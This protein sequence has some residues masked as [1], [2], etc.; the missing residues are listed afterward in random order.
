MPL[1]LLTA[2]LSLLPQAPGAQAATPDD[3]T[4]WLGTAYRTSAA[5]GDV[6]GDGLADLVIGRNGPLSL[7]LGLP[8]GGLERFGPERAVGREVGVSCEQAG[9]PHLVD[10]D[11]DGDLDLVALH[12][13][14]GS[15]GH[16]AWFANDGKGKFAPPLR[17]QGVGGGELPI[18]GQASAIALADWDRD[19]QLDLFVARGEVV[20]HL[21]SRNGF[22]R[23]GVALEITTTGPLAVADTD[24]NGG[25]DVVVGTNN[26]IV[27]HAD[28]RAKPVA[29]QPMA[30]VAADPAQ[31]QIA[32]ADWNGDG[33]L[34]LL[35]V[36][37]QRPVPAAP[38]PLDGAEQA[39]LERCQRLVAVLEAELQ[40]IHRTPPPRDDAA[41][42]QRR[43]EQQQELTQWLAGPREAIAKLQQKG[44]VDAYRAKPKLVL[45][46]R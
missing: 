2:T 20:V 44:A 29:A 15:T 17:L 11:R 9:Q 21:G 40:S 23:D 25:L 41:A 43:S 12:T 8:K 6:D 3:P 27:R 28:P 45:G 35:L 34:D 37:P 19:G 18:D 30:E 7:R 1:H 13:P 33:R 31:A 22:A 24:G 4:H 14:L 36:E 5:L 46:T 42:M 39:H 32:L 38:R 26:A 16:V 10:V